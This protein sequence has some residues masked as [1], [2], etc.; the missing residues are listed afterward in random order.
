K[1]SYLEFPEDIF[2]EV[3]AFN[4]E[5]EDFFE[6]KLGLINNVLSVEKSRAKMSVLKKNSHNVEKKISSILEK[7]KVKEKNIDKVETELHLLRKGPD[8]KKFQSDTEKLE[9][10]GEEKKS[11]ESSIGVELNVLE[12]ALKKLENLTE[13]KKEKKLIHSY[14]TD[15]LNSILN[16]GEKYPGLKTVLNSLLKEVNNESLDLKDRESDKVSIQAKRLLEGSVSKRIESLSKVDAELKRLHKEL[17]NSAV[18]MESQ[19]ERDL[20]EFRKEITVLNVENL[21]EE[22][23]GFDKELTLLKVKLKS[24]LGIALNRTILDN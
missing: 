23:E 14:V 13:D 7:K 8:F 5:L 3:K 11:L 22:K 10:L 1:L 21:V 6:G 24:K 17:D 16:E 9:E 15:S 20:E 2:S 4:N 19:L 18:K 12:R